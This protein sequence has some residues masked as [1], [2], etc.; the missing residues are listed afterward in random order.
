MNDFPGKL[1]YWI[2]WMVMN[3]AKM[4]FY[5]RVLQ[6]LV[7][8]IALVLAWS[9]GHRQFHLLRVGKKTQGEIVGYTTLRFSTSSANGRTGYLPVVEFQI[10]DQVVRFTNWLGSSISPT[11]NQSVPIRYDASHPSLAMIDRPL[12]N[13]IPWAPSSMLG[14]FLILVG[15]KGLLSSKP[16]LSK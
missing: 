4:Q 15:I 2:N 1:N 3:R 12:M 11:P 13:W 7:G 8:L 9:L 5:V 16:A 14:A 6:I 10:E